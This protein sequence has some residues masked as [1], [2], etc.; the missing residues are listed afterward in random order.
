[1]STIFT[2]IINREVSAY[3]IWEDKEV[4][5]FLPHDYFINKGHLLIV[6][7]IEID[8]IFDLDNEVYL[9]LWNIAKILAKPLKKLT[10]A[11]RI[12]IAVEG[13]S[14]PHVH[15]HLTPLYNPSE[16]DPHRNVKWT[17]KER[18]EFIASMKETLKKENIKM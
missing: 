5:A 13:F 14:V 11:K 6:P 10:N 18:K 17:Q 7:K 12:G 9:K 15:I 4:I 1:M 8:H 16:L 2:K 3:I